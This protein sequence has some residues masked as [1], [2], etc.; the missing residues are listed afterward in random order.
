MMDLT[1]S[2]SSPLFQANDANDKD[3]LTGL[4]SM[5]SLI[6]MPQDPM[7]PQ[8]DQQHHCQLTNEV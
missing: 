5:L 3:F 1:I 7:L 6:F 8:S 4:K 2:F